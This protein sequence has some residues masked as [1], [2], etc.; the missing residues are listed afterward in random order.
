[1][2]SKRKRPSR[3]GRYR[4]LGR[5]GSGGM[6]RVYRAAADGADTEVALKVTPLDNDVDVE[7][8]DY[9]REMMVARRV[10]HPRVVTAI[11]HGCADGYIF[12][13]MPIIS[14]A[15][16]SNVTR[17]RDPSRRPSSSK[18][19]AYRDKWAV[20]MLQEQWGQLANLGYQMAEALAACHAGGVIHR[21]VKP[22]NIMM[23]RS[24]DAFL[25]D[26]GL[27]WLHRG[28]RGHELASRAGTARYLP[29]EI[30]DGQRD[31]RSD[32]YSL[33]VTMHELTTGRKIWGEI[34]HETVEK[35]RPELRVPAL[36]SVCPA[37]PQ[38]LAD[39]IDQAAE[40]DPQQRHQT[41][42]E[43]RDHFLL[44]R[45][46]LS[47]LLPGEFTATEV[48]TGIDL[49]TPAQQCLKAEVWFA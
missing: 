39:C 20:P 31:E 3:I 29:P 15:T 13:A 1:M 18:S 28:Q 9:Q 23:D 10:Q 30:F 11:D 17:L 12:L 32:L 38:A 6:S 4:I 5:L 34:D 47:P 2:A 8:A 36:R 43:L 44:V 46:A 22:G 37:V 24:G 40:E 49:P 7:V 41:A 33:G 42:A 21:D 35:Q 14:G 19:S 26:F 48:H 45:N 16:L 27:A 25:M